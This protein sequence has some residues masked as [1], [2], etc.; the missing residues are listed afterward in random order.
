MSWWSWLVGR[1]DPKPIGCVDDPTFGQLRWSDDN[2]SWLGEYGGYL[3]VISYTRA[4][5][6]DPELLAYAREFL[7]EG[8]AAFTRAFAEAK[9]THAK[10]FSGGPMSFPAR[11]SRS[12]CSGSPKAANPVM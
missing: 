6:P 9:V 12:L 10:D 11:P 8:G 7:G 1:R 3:L 4:N 2:D 5:H